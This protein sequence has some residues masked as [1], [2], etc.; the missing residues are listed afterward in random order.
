MDSLF[1]FPNQL[2]VLVLL[3]GKTLRVCVSMCMCSVLLRGPIWYPVIIPPISE[4][5]P[6]LYSYVRHCYCWISVLLLSLFPPFGFFADFFFFVLFL[7]F[8]LYFQ[9]F[10]L[11]FSLSFYLYICGVFFFNRKEGNH[12][13][14]S[15]LNLFWILQG[16]YTRK[17]MAQKSK[18]IFFWKYIYKCDASGIKRE[19]KKNI[20]L[21]GWR[22][23]SIKKRVMRV[24]G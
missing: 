4:G 17:K 9:F 24:G 12:G 16:T 2:L 20:L 19:Q 3:R 6:A 22:I 8:F 10:I 21:W 18:D 5:S 7:Y 11:S 14:G 13:N 23:E 15:R 1:Y